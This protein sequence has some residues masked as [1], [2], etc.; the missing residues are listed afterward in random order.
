MRFAPTLLLVAVLTAFAHAQAGAV[1]PKIAAGHDY[2]L[3]LRSDGTLWGWGSN[4]YGQLAIKSVAAVDYPQPRSGMNDISAIAPGIALKADGTAWMLGNHRYINYGLHQTFFDACTTPGYPCAMA[5]LQ[6]VTALAGGASYFAAVRS[7][8]TVWGWGDNYGGGTIGNGVTETSGTP[9]PVPGLSG[10]SAVSVGYGHALA[11]KNDGTVWGWG[12]NDAGQLG[13]PIIGNKLPL[14]VENL[15]DVVA[16][17]AGFHQSLALKADGTVWNWGGISSPTVSQP[18]QVSLPRIVAIATE[19]DA[20]H[21]LALDVDGNVWA[22]G[23]NDYGQLGT[24]DKTDSA[25]PVRVSGLSQVVAI[26][27]GSWHS[28]AILQD[29]TVWIWGKTNKPTVASIDQ[30]EFVYQNTHG[31]YATGL[32]TVTQ[33]PCA[34]LPRQALDVSGKAFFVTAQTVPSATETLPS[35]TDRL[36]NYLEGEYAYYLSTRGPAC[37]AAGYVCRYYATTNAY[38]GTRD[39]KLYYLGPESGQQILELGSVADWLDTAKRTGW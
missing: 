38:V 1:S 7:D 37:Q 3:V 10:I 19:D 31:P 30:C 39:G 32:T 6:G 21:S 27:A 14:P 29:G 33:E 4:G 25:T 17:A 22:W 11:L 9:A 12:Y 5:R 36:F 35:D 8:G 28:V 34:K 16:I 23:R 26:A 2:T 18:R 20:V 13:T 15:T 24:G